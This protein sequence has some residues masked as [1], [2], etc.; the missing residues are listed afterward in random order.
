MLTLKGLT[1]F[2]LIT[3]SHVMTVVKFN[4]VKN[5][6]QYQAGPRH[7]ETIN[8]SYVRHTDKVYTHKQRLCA[9]LN[10]LLHPR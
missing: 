10:I 2:E 3:V 5:H 9:V 1:G 8:T 6:W 4:N 7:T